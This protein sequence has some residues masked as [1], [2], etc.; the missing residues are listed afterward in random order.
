MT[1]ALTLLAGPDA[2]RILLE[3]GLVA[4]DVDVIPGASGGPKWLVLAGLDR[5]VFGDFLRAPRTRPL[6]LVGSSIGSWRLACAAQPDPVAAL[7]RAHDAY[8]EQRYP[9]RPSAALVTETTARI[10]DALLGETGA[11]EIVRHP[12][13]RLHVITTAC[14]GLLGSERRVAQTAGVALA[15]A[16]NLASRAALALQA[17]RVVFHAD[18]DGKG[19]TA[20][21]GSLAACPLHSLDDLPTDHAPLTQENLRLALLA[22]ASIPLWLEGVAIRG[23]RAA[24]TGT[25]ASSTIT[26]TSTSGR[27][28][29]SSSTLTST[30]TSSRAGSTRRFPSGGRRPGTSA[31]SSSSRRPPS[32]SPRSRTRRSPTGPTSST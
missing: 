4:A 26:S 27:A 7:A 8:V 30:R 24:S 2:R 15:A 18:G 31:A 17:R 12:W 23:R 5:F 13:A 21:S 16:G 11:R 22:S 19:E 20:G 9:R 29:A 3:R 28:T 1:P 14:R 32:S 25:A 6:T 10:L